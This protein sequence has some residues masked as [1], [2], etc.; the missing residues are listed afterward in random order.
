MNR[1]VMEAMVVGE[2]GEIVSVADGA[3]ALACLEARGADAFDAVLTDVQMPGIDGYEL[4]ARIAGLAPALPVI[5]VTAHAMA[6]EAERCRAAGMADR[7]TK[8]VDLER[9]VAA[10]LGRVRGAGDRPPPFVEP[11][12][13]PSVAL[14]AG[15]P[16]GPLV[17]ERVILERIGGN[18]EVLPRMVGVAA[19]SVVAV[20]GH[21]RDALAAGD[22]EAMAFNAHYAKGTAGYLELPWLH[23]MALAAEKAA[24]DGAAD[25]PQ[26][27]EQLARALERLIEDLDRLAASLKS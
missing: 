7:L 20:P 8:P 1:L 27:I 10:V 26:R 5:G 11:D 21:L 18:R 17:D 15:I 19:E 4:A 14:A 2:G 6:E 16:D 22:R 25:A 9:L 23:A 3:A 12:A 13:R 24:R